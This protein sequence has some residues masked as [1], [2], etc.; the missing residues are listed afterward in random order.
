M[1]GNMSE[2]KQNDRT[3]KSVIEF[4]CSNCG[5]KIRVAKAEAGHKG[6][7]PGCKG[8]LVVPA[9]DVQEITGG[10]EN[11]GGEKVSMKDLMDPAVFE[12]P[13]E[14]SA[15]A[16]TAGDDK[17]IVNEIGRIIFFVMFTNKYFMTTIPLY[18]LCAK[19]N[20]GRRE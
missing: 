5:R 4:F 13:P 15:P 2:S 3:K 8:A 6:R 10:E 18:F 7:C 11:S 19:R 1:E 14:E 12:L 20:L 17:V 16:A 9:A